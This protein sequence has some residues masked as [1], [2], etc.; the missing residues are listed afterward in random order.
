MPTFNTA[1][2]T[3]VAKH[4]VLVRELLDINKRLHL[5]AGKPG[6]RA[7]IASRARA[8]GHA[9]NGTAR[10]G[11]HGKVAK[12]KRHSWFE[13][14]EA[15]TLMQSIAK[16]PMTQADLVRAIAA[17]KKITENLSTQN[18]KRFQS[19]TF[20]AIANAVAGRKMIAARDGTVRARA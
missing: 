8:D 15:I 12:G 5:V 7:P 3:L 18:Q 10:N 16:K 14:G 19:A 4:D 13:R 17:K 6:A 11:V 1:F 2:S 20:Q 9:A